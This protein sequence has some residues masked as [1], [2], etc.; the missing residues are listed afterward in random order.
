VSE[1][2]CERVL[3]LPLFPEMTRVQIETVCSVVRGA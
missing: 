2:V 1:S 3:S